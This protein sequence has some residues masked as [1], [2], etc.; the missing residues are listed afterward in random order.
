[1]ARWPRDEFRRVVNDK[2]RRAYGCRCAELLV[3]ERWKG[4]MRAITGAGGR[5][6]ER[7]PER[8]RRVGGLMELRGAVPTLRHFC[9]G[10]HQALIC[11]LVQ[12]LQ[13]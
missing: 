13:Y 7:C 11:P 6:D 3:A 4:G 2:D 10:C 12:Q 9:Y 1:M 5:G 8:E